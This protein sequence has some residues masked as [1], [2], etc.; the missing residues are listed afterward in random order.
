MVGDVGIVHTGGVSSFPLHWN[1][2][3]VLADALLWRCAASVSH[4]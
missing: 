4:P 1:I 3:Q 2:T